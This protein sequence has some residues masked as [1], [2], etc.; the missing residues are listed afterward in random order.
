MDELERSPADKTKAGEKHPIILILDDIRSMHNVGA[1]FRTA[2]AFAV[3]AIYL[4]GYTPV[5]PHRDIHKTALGATET[6]WWRHFAN[7][8]D[9]V[10]QAREEG[11][12]IYAVEQTH[13]SIPLHNFNA[14]SEPVALVFWE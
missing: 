1:A 12:K 7:T 14:R 4:C 3:T 10:K 13:N 2:D 6:V 8:A 9:A 11:Y 5:P